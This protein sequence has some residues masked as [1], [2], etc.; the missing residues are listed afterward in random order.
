MAQENNHIMQS[1]TDILT[2]NE[3][4]HEYRGIAPITVDNLYDTISLDPI[5]VTKLRN[6]NT[7]RVTPS[8]NAQGNT[9]YTIEVT[10]G[11]GRSYTGEYPLQ[12]NN[13]TN[14]IS[15]NNV[16][17]ALEYPLKGVVDSDTMV[18]GAESDTTYYESEPVQTKTIPSASTSVN[19][20]N[21]FTLTAGY[22][23]NGQFTV[24]G[25]EFADIGVDMHTF[26]VRLYY[27]DPIG[28]TER[29]L[30]EFPVLFSS[31]MN[32]LVI[33]VTVANIFSLDISLKI[34]LSG[35]SFKAGTWNYLFTGYTE[36][37]W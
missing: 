15:V 17:L 5:A 9:Q 30:L 32:K 31:V 13:D 19:E 18:L 35:I 34:Q 4:T 1:Y 6:S 8:V 28:F 37:I 25:I 10:D 7:T 12:V 36:K 2:V 24:S 33:P 26:L 21:A 14:T 3:N 23:M 16:G 22:R 11:A 27:D 20:S 29:T